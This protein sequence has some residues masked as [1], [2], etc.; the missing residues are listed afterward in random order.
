MDL[1]RLTDRFEQDP[2]GKE[3]RVKRFGM[4]GTSAEVEICNGEY[5]V[6]Y[7]NGKRSN[8]KSLEDCRLKLEEMTR[9]R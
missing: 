2:N 1:T 6:I 7:S 9:R 5:S 8:F 4:W 3:I